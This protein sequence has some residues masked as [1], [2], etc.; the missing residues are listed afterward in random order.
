MKCPYSVRK[1]FYVWLGEQACRMIPNEEGLFKEKLIKC[2]WFDRNKI[3]WGLKHKKLYSLNKFYNVQI[4][5]PLYTNII[6]YKNIMNFK[7][8]GICLPKTLSIQMENIMS[9]KIGFNEWILKEPFY[10][11]CSLLQKRNLL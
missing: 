7:I 2:W 11:V 5:S 3:R 1:L 8:A 10:C 6:F 9:I 4:I